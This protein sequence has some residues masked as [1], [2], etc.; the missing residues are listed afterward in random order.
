MTAISVARKVMETT[1]H[2]F[3]VGEDA[4]QFAI[5]MGFQTQNLSTPRSIQMWQQ[6]VAGGCKPNFHKTNFTCPPSS[7]EK[8]REIESCQVPKSELFDE[9]NHDTIG[10]VAVDSS[11]MVSCGTS[12]NGLTYKIAGR[13]GDSPI[14]GSGAY[15]DSTVG[16]AAA[17]GVGDI[18]MRFSP[19]FKAVDLMRQGMDPT[20]G[21]RNQ[22]IFLLKKEL[23]FLIPFSSMSTSN[24]TN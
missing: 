16:G 18:I 7:S 19:S 2:T 1:T 13:V 14:P 21:E 6:W 8:K 22:N 10:M 9:G 17:T 4:T 11:G 5:Q 12:T 15:C 24:N 3:L 20:Q 23:I